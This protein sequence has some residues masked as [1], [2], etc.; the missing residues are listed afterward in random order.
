MKILLYKLFLLVMLITTINSV[1]VTNIVHQGIL[2]I[3]EKIDIMDVSR[4]IV[5]RLETTYD[6]LELY[7][8]YIMKI[9]RFLSRNEYFLKDIHIY[10]NSRLLLIIL[11]S[12]ASENKSDT[13]SDSE[14]LNKVIVHLSIDIVQVDSNRYS[15]KKIN[16]EQ[17]KG[18]I[19]KKRRIKLGDIEV[20]QKTEMQRKREKI[21][22]ANAN[23][24]TDEEKEE[25]EKQKKR[26]QKHNYD[27]FNKLLKRFEKWQKRAKGYNADSHSL[28]KKFKSGTEEV[29]HEDIYLDIASLVED[30]VQLKMYI[31]N[32]EAH[33][34]SL[35]RS[36]KKEDGSI[37][38]ERANINLKVLLELK[39]ENEY[40]TDVLTSLVPPEHGEPSLDVKDSLSKH[41]KTV[42]KVPQDNSLDLSSFHAL[43]NSIDKLTL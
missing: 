19:N 7:D 20:S 12:E 38:L 5:S 10:E 3:N 34:D 28:I 18:D 35:D 22:I 15:N 16:L 26:S 21:F 17:A 8:Q 29:S 25:R 14:T 6:H 41:S 4:N 32:I 11:T 42:P 9:A 36:L 23:K 27:S 43:Y 31:Y 40:L 33:L 37:F 13:D 39:K 1:P 30:M 2:N 24:E